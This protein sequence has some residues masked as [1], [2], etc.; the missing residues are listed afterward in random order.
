MRKVEIFSC[1]HDFVFFVMVKFMILIFNLQK[2]L[3]WWRNVD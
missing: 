2:L 1:F 3:F